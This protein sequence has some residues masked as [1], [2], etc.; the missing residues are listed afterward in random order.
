MNKWKQ[1]IG[2][3]FW[4]WCNYRALWSRYS[5]VFCITILALFIISFPRFANA[6]D[7]L[8]FSECISIG[9]ERN[10]SLKM[11]KNTEQM[12]RNDYKFGVM[13]MMPTLMANGTLN[14]SV[15]N[16]KQLFLLW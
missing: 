6:Q 11:V 12:A 5:P 13:L 9:L 7:S 16:S 15:I 1:I 10:Y 2:F 3:D 8:S 4:I 14:N